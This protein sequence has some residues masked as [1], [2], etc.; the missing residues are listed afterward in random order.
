[1]KKCPNCGTENGDDLVFCKQCG[2][3]LTE[4][5]QPVVDLKK[6]EVPEKDEYV[7]PVTSPAA[8]AYVPPVAAPAPQ[9]SAPAPT[10]R[11][12]SAKAIAGMCLGLSGL[13]C[14]TVAIIC[15]IVGVSAIYKTEAVAGGASGLVWALIGL[16]CGIPGIILGAKGYNAGTAPANHGIAKCGKVTSLITIIICGVA[17][18]LA[19]I[20]L[21]VH[22]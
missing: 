6:P 3:S 7:P 14:A 11:K 20:T 9:F 19:I 22:G 2:A 4:E 18:T 16:G 12:V 8:A 17:L 21:A 13:V 15:A 5:E 10:V 1:M